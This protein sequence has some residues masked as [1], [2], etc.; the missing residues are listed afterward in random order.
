ML[1]I[2]AG[3]AAFPLSYFSLRN[4]AGMSWGAWSTHEEAEEAD[5]AGPLCRCGD[6]WMTLP[7]G[8][9]IF[10]DRRPGRGDSIRNGVHYIPFQP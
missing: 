8:D 3:R 1:P 2:P 10:V 7:N 9:E 6:V 4:A 5:G